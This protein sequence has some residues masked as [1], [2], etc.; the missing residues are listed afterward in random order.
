MEAST[1]PTTARAWRV[2]LMSES[3]SMVWRR[4]RTMPLGSAS[5]LANTLTMLLAGT[6]RLAMASI[7]ERASMASRITVWA[8]M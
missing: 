8:Q 5:A 1:A 7:T 4:P 6:G 3:S 2:W